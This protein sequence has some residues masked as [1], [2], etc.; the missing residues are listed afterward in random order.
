MPYEPKGI[1]LYHCSFIREAIIALSPFGRP[2]DVHHS[3]NVSREYTAR[4]H[5][6]DMGVGLAFRYCD[7]Y[8]AVMADHGLTVKLSDSK[9]FLNC[10]GRCQ[11]KINP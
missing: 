1:T 9:G 3:H 11:V 5:T 6:G 10:D 7:R 2:F 8:V 4:E